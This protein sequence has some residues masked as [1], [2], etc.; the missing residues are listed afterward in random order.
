M[1]LGAQRYL[2]SVEDLSKQPEEGESFVCGILDSQRVLAF[3]ERNL[4]QQMVKIKTF[5]C[6][7]IK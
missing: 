3:S 4:V 2:A 5:S 7:N 1:N 6:Q